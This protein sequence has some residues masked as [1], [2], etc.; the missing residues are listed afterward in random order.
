MTEL[1]LFGGEP[2]IKK[3][4]NEYVSIGDEEKK[5]VNEVMESGCISG[6]YGS[7]EE[8]MFF[9]GKKA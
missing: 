5:A 4:L 9:G 2:E 6:F 1:A 8:G 3:P 7:W